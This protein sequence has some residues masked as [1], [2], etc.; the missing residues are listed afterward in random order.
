MLI[1]ECPLCH[2]TNRYYSFLVENERFDECWDCGLLTHTSLKNGNTSSFVEY[3]S[4]D[5]GTNENYEWCKIVF[6]SLEEYSHNEDGRHIGL[7]GD[8]SSLFMDEAGKRNFKVD[9]INLDERIFKKYGILFL[10][11]ILENTEKPE[12][13]VT[14]LRNYL[15]ENGIIVVITKQLLKP[16]ARGNSLQILD[17]RQLY[18]FSDHNLQMILYKA[19]FSE[20]YLYHHLEKKNY[21]QVQRWHKN[22]GIACGRMREICSVPKLSVLLPVYNES[23]TVRKVMEALKTKEIPGIDIEVI[24]VESLS[25]DG[26]REIVLEYQENPKFKIIME[27]YPRGKGCAVREAIRHATGDIILIQDAD[28][29]YDF[30]DYEILINPILLGRTSFVLGTRHAGNWKIRQFN[31]YFLAD[32]MNLGHW[33]LVYLMNRL[34]GQKMTDPF[35]MF[36]VFRRDCLFGLT[37]ECN[38]F[39][40]DIE[41]VCKLLR[42]GYIP[43][44]IPVNYQA[45]S[46][47]EGKK[48][49]IFRD[50][51]TWI[52]AM[53]KY[54]F[55]SVFSFPEN[56]MLT[57]SASVSK[58]E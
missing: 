3:N 15:V 56:S 8:V 40:F 9:K 4:E 20:L 36:K 45:R 43:L 49:R 26:S 57:R 42:K 31:Q 6:S 25:S 38:R 55:V 41:L 29:E 30:Q 33:S 47:K 27:E 32:I 19:G 54:R 5:S 21:E 50:P 18:S 23:G 44:E 51:L 52:K 46:F 17:K 11:N 22:V 48:V 7:V 13:F 34:F 35:T 37:F 10:V 1:T 14:S 58:I 39:D 2:G 28:L 16:G 24:V 12:K 53:L